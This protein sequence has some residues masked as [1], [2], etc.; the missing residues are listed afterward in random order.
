V[1]E[2][3]A[4]AGA[5]AA[6]GVDA[7]LCVGRGGAFEDRRCSA[8]GGKTEET[9]QKNN[10]AYTGEKVWIMG[11]TNGACDKVAHSLCLGCN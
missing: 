3:V 8:G 10:F 11:E 9:F 1:R 6:G 7:E 5:P 2:Q 4:A